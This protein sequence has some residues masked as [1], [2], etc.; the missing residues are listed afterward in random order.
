MATGGIFMAR[1]QILVGYAEVIGLL[2]CAE[3][4]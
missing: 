4:N 2:A 3:E 1:N